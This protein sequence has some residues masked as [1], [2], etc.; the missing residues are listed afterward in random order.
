MNLTIKNY[1]KLKKK[2]WDSI[3]FIEDIVEKNDCYEI[4]VW[5]GHMRHFVILDREQLGN[6]Y[7]EIG[8]WSNE[9]H[10]VEY[11]YWIKQ[12]DILDIE[13]LMDKL[14]ILT[15]DWKPKLL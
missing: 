15:D 3:N 8:E 4:S 13:S 9:A 7:Y 2:G 12:E 14:K 1:E 5:R 6:G 10:C 11:P